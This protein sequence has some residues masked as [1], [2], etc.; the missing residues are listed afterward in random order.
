METHIPDLTR[1]FVKTGFTEV[2]TFENELIP[3]VFMAC[4]HFSKPGT[5]K[6]WSTVFTIRISQT[7][8]PILL[9]VRTTGCIPMDGDV[10]SM[11]F[12][13][14]VPLFAVADDDDFVKQ[15]EPVQ[16]WQ[17]KHIEQHRFQLYELSLRLAMT[18]IAPY[19][20]N[21]VGENQ[22]LWEPVEKSF[23]SNEIRAITRILNKKI[24]QKIT[25]DFLKQISEIYTVAGLAGENPVKAIQEHFKC[26]HRTA[27]DYASKARKKGFLPETEPGIVTVKKASKKKGK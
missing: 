23:T 25:P 3:N 6:I 14:G 15:I 1:A 26:S 4:F 11:D 20:V 18:T 13:H 17:L 9:E 12:Y 22:S 7:G 24:R 8:T 19:A 5:G 27:S 16:R 10:R 2:S 21:E